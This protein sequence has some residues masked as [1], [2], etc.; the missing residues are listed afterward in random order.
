MQK[1]SSGFKNLGQFVAA[2]HVSNNLG[3][4]FDQLKSTMMGPPEK[5][6]GDAIHQIKPDVNAKAE[7]N[8]AKKQ[9]DKDMK[10]SRS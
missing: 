10:E 9:A 3:I 1:A 6:L 4:P 7:A 8:K 5:S 2:A